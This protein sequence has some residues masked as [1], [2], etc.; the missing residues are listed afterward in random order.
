MTTR[1]ED[2]QDQLVSLLY[3]GEPSDPAVKDHVRQCPQCSATLQSYQQVQSLFQSL[4]EVNPPPHLT[5]AIFEKVSARPREPLGA[6]LSRFFLHPASVAVIVFVLTL[7]GTLIAKKYYPWLPRDNSQGTAVAVKDSGSSSPAADVIPAARP[8]FVRANLRM[9]DWNPMPTMIPDLERPVLKTT[10]TPSLE[11]AS[12]E[13]VAA[14]KHH[15]A[16][17]H[18]VD[19]EFSKAHEILDSIAENYLNYSQWERA[20]LLHMS[21]MKKLGRTED[22]QRDVARLREYA[23]TSPAVL[24]EIADEIR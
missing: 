23:M 5:D 16:L 14:F 13:S 8:H 18:I 3:E 12:I 6:W 24:S 21:L 2:V 9:V 22:I 10:D 20:V 15:I 19:G 1:C 17:R 4:P 7:G 11:Q